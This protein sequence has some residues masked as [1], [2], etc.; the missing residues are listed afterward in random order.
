MTDF[1]NGLERPLIFGHRGLSDLAPENTLP[2]FQMCVDKGVPAVELDVHLCATGELVVIHDS[3][4]KRV[5]GEDMI[6]EETSFQ[7]LRQVDVG[8]HK[9]AQFAGTR[10]PLLSELFELCGDKLIYDIEIKRNGILGSR[11]EQAV[12]DTIVQFCLQGKCMVSSFNPFSVRKFRSLSKDKIPTSV[13][14]SR[15][16]DVPRAFRRGAGRHIARCSYLKPSYKVVDEKMIEK[17]QE[18]KG[19]PV[20]VWTVNTREDYQRMANLGVKGVIG[21]S[22]HLFL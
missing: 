1:F 19:Y 15:D 6:V 11:L 5:S 18:K 17:F 3:N 7:R 13:I 12:W 10:I 2:A 22:P 20:V 16:S 8:S 9:G 4:L 21:N 14:Y